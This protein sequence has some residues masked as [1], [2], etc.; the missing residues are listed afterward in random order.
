[1]DTVSRSQSTLAK[2]PRLAPATY[3]AADTFGLF[4]V[5]YTSGMEQVRAGTF[6]VTPIRVGRQLKFSRAEVDRLLGLNDQK[7]GAPEQ[8]VA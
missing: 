8:G 4:G 6:P 5:G 3:G 1:M 2:R 7:D